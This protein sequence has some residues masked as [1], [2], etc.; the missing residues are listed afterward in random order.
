MQLP[1]IA[2]SRS[3]QRQIFN[4]VVHLFVVSVGLQRF[5]VCLSCS[6]AFSSLWIMEPSRIITQAQKD[7][8][9]QTQKTNKQTKTRPSSPENVVFD[10]RYFLEL[11]FSIFL[12][13]NLPFARFHAVI[14]ASLGT[15]LL[16]RQRFVTTTSTAASAFACKFRAIMS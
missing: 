14:S 2:K 8:K 3:F 4:K 12:N 6:G 11:L 5:S 15:F 10:G 7:Q 13:L 1:L 9:N 16:N